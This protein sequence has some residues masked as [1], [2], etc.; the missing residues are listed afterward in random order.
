M[1][2]VTGSHLSYFSNKTLCEPVC[3]RDDSQP[4]EILLFFDK[5]ARFCSNWLQK[6]S[7]SRLLKR[8]ESCKIIKMSLKGSYLMGKVDYYHLNIYPGQFILLSLAKKARICSN[9]VQK[10]SL[11][12][13]LKWGQISKIIKMSPKGSDLTGKIG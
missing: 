10:R 7:L 1:F 13:P 3:T 12:R 4:L 11:S 5:T 6:R 2:L 8:D 9:W